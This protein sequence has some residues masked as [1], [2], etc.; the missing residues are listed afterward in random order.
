LTT[1]AG[2][3]ALAGA[4]ACGRASR[5][6][7]A[8]ASGAAALALLCVL[9]GLRPPDGGHLERGALVATLAAL[10]LSFATTTAWLAAREP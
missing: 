10:A 7:G 8:V 1:L 2:L 3:V 9:I 4:L 5:P 6:A